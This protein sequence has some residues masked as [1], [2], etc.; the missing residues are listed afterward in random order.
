MFSCFNSSMNIDHI[1]HSFA[2]VLALAV[3]RLYPGVQFGIGP[4]TES[5]FYYDFDFSEAEGSPGEDDLA[6]TQKEMHKIIGENLV[7]E[8]EDVS[9]AKAQEAMQGQPYKLELIGD[10]VTYGTTD[11]AEIKK[12]SAK[13]GPA[14]GGKSPDITLYTIGEFTDLC[15]GGHV[16]ST[17]KLNKDAFSLTHLAGAYWRGDETQPQMLRIYGLAFENK[18][19]LKEHEALLEEARKRDHKKLGPELDL[20]SFSPLVGPGLPLWTPKG[21]LL[22]DL[23]D[24]Y[25][26]QLRK[27]KGYERVEIPHLTKKALYETSGHWDKFGDDL[28][29]IET[30]DGRELSVKPMNCPHHTQIYDR[31]PHSYRELPIRYA[32]TTMVYRDEQSGELSGLTRVLSITQDDAHV[33]CRYDQV[34]DEIEK[35]WDIVDTFYS[36]FG[37]D[38]WVRLSLRDSDEPDKYLGDTENWDSSEATLKELA[39]KRDVKTQEAVGEA[40]FYGPKVDFM[41]TD[42]LGRE[43]Q[44]A[45]I[46]LDMNMPERFNLTCVNEEGEKERVAMLHAAIMGSLERFLGVLIEHLAGAFP[47]WLAPV[48]AVVLP[49]SEKQNEYGSA[50]LEELKAA[51]IRTEMPSAD[52]TLGKRIREAELQKIPYI[53]VVGDNEKDAGTVTVRERGEDEQVEQSI[54]DFVKQAQEKIDTKEL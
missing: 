34:G 26:W 18:N 25:V 51:G 45:T 38:L 29:K 52:E 28:F 42:S 17:G 1:R 11:A 40:A 32:N 21:T 37:F 12:A 7:F 13:G 54:A 15:R 43:W 31:K 39:Q 41:A 5:G 22:R 16:E 9:P 10:L 3:K 35:I 30:R 20:F 24:A 27:E 6:R 50:V 46:Q 47:V 49:I 8:K 53:L 19:E 4:V 33:F 48:Q 14:S 44:V 36:T 23:L 2:H